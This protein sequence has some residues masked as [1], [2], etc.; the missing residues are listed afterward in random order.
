MAPTDDAPSLL[1]LLSSPAFGKPLVGSLSEDA[2]NLGELYPDWQDLVRRRAVRSI[3][4]IPVRGSNGVMGCLTLGCLDPLIWEEQWWYGGMQLLSGWAATVLSQHQPTGCIDFF[5]QLLQAEDLSALAAAFVHC[6]PA[7]LHGEDLGG[8]VEARLALVSS[9]LIRALV[10]VNEPGSIYNSSQ[11]LQ[12]LM[13]PDRGSASR[14]AQMEKPMPG[15]SWSPRPLFPVPATA[16]AGSAVLSM[17][18]LRRNSAGSSDSDKEGEK[19]REG[20]DKDSVT[21]AV[22]RLR[23]AMSCL[24]SESGGSSILNTAPAAV[25]DLESN[26]AAAAEEEDSSASPQTLEPAERN[27]DSPSGSLP[28]IGRLMSRSLSTGHRNNSSAVQTAAAIAST[29]RRIRRRSSTVTAA[30]AAAAGLLHIG[31]STG[32][33]GAGGHRTSALS[34]GSFALAYSGNHAL[35]ASRR[36]FGNCVSIPTDGTLLMSALEA[37]DVMTVN[38]SLVYLGRKRVVGGGEGGGRVIVL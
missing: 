7:S 29:I 33:D 28:Q 11:E 8:K 30:G 32:G 14:L 37:G 12:R 3:L 15:A 2:S 27:G 24:P 17:A 9:R 18:R 19:E 25:F 10:Y 13:Q 5:E 1:A 34:S 22:M 16:P 23:R 35:P 36:F 31:D 20:G 26:T 6:L 21:A 38:D 4:S